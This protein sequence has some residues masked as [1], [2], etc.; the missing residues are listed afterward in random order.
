MVIR[1]DGSFSTALLDRQAR[2]EDTNRREAEYAF[3]TFRPFNR[4]APLR[5]NTIIGSSR[6]K[7]S[8]RLLR[9]RGL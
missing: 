1:S 9:V 5:R 3:D 6:L 4:F 7:R 2:R 8:N